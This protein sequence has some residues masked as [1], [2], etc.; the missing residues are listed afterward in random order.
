MK[1]RDGA[2]HPAFVLQIISESKHYSQIRIAV[3]WQGKPACHE[4]V[5]LSR[6]ARGLASGWGKVRKLT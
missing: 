6:Q 5:C 1:K 4:D 2:C 3:R